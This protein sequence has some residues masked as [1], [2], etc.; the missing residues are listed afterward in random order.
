[1]EPGRGKWQQI[2]GR[3]VGTALEPSN[4]PL[5][6]IPGIGARCSRLDKLTS[7]GVVN[8]GSSDPGF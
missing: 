8:E 2:G 7:P 1:M 6:A 3:C 4:W 5:C